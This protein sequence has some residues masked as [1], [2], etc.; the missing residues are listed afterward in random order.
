MTAFRPPHEEVFV[1]RGDFDR[2][3]R[4]WA[5]YFVARC[6][7]RPEESVLDIGSGIGRVAIPLTDYLTGRYEGFDI[8]SEGIEW[9]ATNVTPRFPNFRFRHVDVHN[10]LYNPG[11]L[12][13]PAEFR[14]PYGDDEFD[15]VFLTSVFTHMLPREVEHYI[16][17]IARVLRPGKRCLASV[18]LMGEGVEPTQPQLRFDEDAGPYCFNQGYKPED[19]L[20]Y[21]EEFLLGLFERH[22]FSPSVDYGWWGRP[23]SETNLDAQDVV[24]A[25]LG[26]LSQASRS[27]G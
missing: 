20:A 3:G 21:K 1:G 5:E 4:Q 16:A 26:D 11:G 2:I 14:F 27:A 23:R 19:V 6:D 25:R 10:A 12:L 24:L 18:F 8:V 15:F 7:L 9:C 17:E 22:G 13:S